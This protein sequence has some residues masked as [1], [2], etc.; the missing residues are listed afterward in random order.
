MPL[1]KYSKKQI[2][3]LLKNKY[4]KNFTTVVSKMTNGN[5]NNNIFTKYFY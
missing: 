3:E 4:V 5:P 1:I 2:E